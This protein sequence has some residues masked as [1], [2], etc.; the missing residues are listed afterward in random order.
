MSKL[1]VSIHSTFNGVVTGPKDD[2]TNFATWAQAGI[3]DS[4]PSF[5]ENFDTVD[6]IL[7]GPRHIRGSIDEMAFCCEQAMRRSFPVR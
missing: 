5:H 7:L 6:T 3:E 1:I 2:E 4:V